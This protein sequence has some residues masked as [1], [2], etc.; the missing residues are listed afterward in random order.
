MTCPQCGEACDQ[1]SEGFCDSCYSRNQAE[2]DQHNAE[3]AAWAK[4]S[5]KARE[6]RIQ[7]ELRR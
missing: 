4:L 1:L 7:E 3:Y 6:H 2:L 5:K